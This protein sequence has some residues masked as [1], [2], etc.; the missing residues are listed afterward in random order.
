[1]K[2]E[3]ADKDKAA[4]SAVQGLLKADKA[5]ALAVA[6]LLASTSVTGCTSLP[7]NAPCTGQPDGVNCVQP[8]GAATGWLNQPAWPA[9]EGTPGGAQGQHLATDK[10]FIAN[11]QYTKL[12][13]G[14]SGSSTRPSYYG[15]SHYYY[16]R[17]GGGTTSG[18]GS[19]FSS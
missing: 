6:V 18:G 7:H 4:R 5:K 12:R 11:P 3:K 1:M 2:N 17:S 13:A 14:S 15:G 9:V 10:D 8:S 19:G 16:Y